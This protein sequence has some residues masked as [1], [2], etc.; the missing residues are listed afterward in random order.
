MAL[1][2]GEGGFVERKTC[3]ESMKKCKEGVHRCWVCLA[4][5][6]AVLSIKN[7]FAGN[8]NAERQRQKKEI[9]FSKRSLGEAGAGK[10]HLVAVH[11]QASF[12][13]EIFM[14]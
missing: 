10:E 2:E 14:Y 7:A 4:G 13:G 1:E 6:A 9:S 3:T 8:S 5:A 11:R 12:R